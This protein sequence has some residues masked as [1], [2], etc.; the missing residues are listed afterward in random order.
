MMQKKK[1]LFPLLQ[2]SGLFFLV[3]LVTPAYM[4]AQKKAKKDQIALIREFIQIC[5]SYKKVPLH[6]SVTIHRNADVITSAIDTASTSAEFFISE[7]GTYIKMDELEQVVN[8]SLMLLISN[9]AKRMVLYP[10]NTPVGAQLNNN[11][12]IQLQDSSLEKIA[13]KY[14]ASLISSREGEQGSH[15]IEV[16]SKNKILNT[17]LPKEAIRVKYDTSTKQP[18]EVEQVF[19][20]L[21]PLDSLEYKNLLLK[22]EYAEKLVA[23]DKNGFFLVNKHAITFIYKSIES[24]NNIILPVQL[25]SCITK[26]TSGQYA[27]AKRYEGFMLTGNF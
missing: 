16:Q 14:N 24:N 18:R 7:K 5:N 9:N 21:I 3:L 11:M 26:N 19:R 25:D 2:R 1:Y 8:D 27:V 17:S 15:I 20:K 12:G 10:N 13:K 4:F 23:T 22:P 6:L